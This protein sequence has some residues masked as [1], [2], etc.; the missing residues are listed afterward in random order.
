MTHLKQIIVTAVLLLTAHAFVAAQT[1]AP[2]ACTQSAKASCVDSTPCKTD[3]SGNTACLAGA[4]LPLGAVS[5]VQSCWQYGYTF[6]C[7]GTSTN[8]C[9][10]YSSNSLC[11]QASSD[12][13]GYLGETGSCNSWTNSYS[14]QT[15]AAITTPQ[16]QCSS[17]LT[18]A[19]AIATPAA[20]SSNFVQAALALEI[21]NET[22]TYSTNSNNIFYGVSEACTVGDLGIKNCCRTTPGGQSNGMVFTMVFGATGTIVKY[23][24]E[25]AIDAASPYV[26]DTLYAIGNPYSTSM[27]QSMIESANIVATEGGDIVA[28]QFAA[29][30]MSLGAYGFTYSSVALTGAAEASAGLP[31]GTSG[32]YFNPYAFAAYAAIQIIE[33]LASCTQAEQLLGV[34]RGANLSQFENQYCSN[35]LPMINTC[36]EWTSKYCSFN[37]VLAKIINIQGKAQLGLDPSSCS[38]LT[39]AQLTQLNMSKIDFSQF[40]A[41][42]TSQAQANLPTSST[43][44]TN[45]QPIVNAMKSGSSQNTGS[46]VL[47][48]SK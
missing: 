27:Y 44:S 17:N 12:C 40:T 31:L 26:F 1:L 19:L 2:G 11:T 34:H 45:Y 18:S 32:V 22:Q 33:N 8:T 39:Q 28:T 23:A 9:T 29:G 13:N 25:Q 35:K 43:M 24:G 15:Q 10:Q 47:P 16:T 14:C 30:G 38:G 42:M 48:S 36:V 4:T 21:A 3:A 5:L 7:Q 37:S 6:T 46:A 41:A 20:K